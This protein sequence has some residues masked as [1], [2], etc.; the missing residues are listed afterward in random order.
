MAV[1]AV[2]VLLLG[3]SWII[4]LS[5]L[6]TTTGDAYIVLG[7]VSFYLLIAGLI[8]LIIAAIPGIA[9]YSPLNDQEP[10]RSYARY[11]LMCTVL[12][13]VTFLGSL[14]TRAVW[15]VRV[16]PPL[17]PIV[18]SAF[19][20]GFLGY[21]CYMGYRI[22]NP[23]LDRPEDDIME[24]D[25]AVE[26]GASRQTTQARSATTP[27]GTIASASWKKAELDEQ[28]WHVEPRVDAD[29]KTL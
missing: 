11:H 20:V 5:N 25:R 29:G 24:Y 27:P 3:A 7:N 4:D 17:V 6:P 8:T 9:D 10:V 2:P 18:L 13:F 16:G 26:S 22:A 23:L 12:S 1:A 19:G 15:P 14:L 28:R 21:A